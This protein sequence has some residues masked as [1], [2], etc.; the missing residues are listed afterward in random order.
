MG[1]YVSFP[2]GMMAAFLNRPLVL[3]EQNSIPGLANRVLAQLADRVLT[4]FPDAF[5][6]KAKV[7]WTGNPVRAAIAGLPEPAIRYGAR[8]GRLRLLV[9]GG[10][11]GA[12]ALNG[13]VPRALALIAEAQRPSVTH[14]SGVNHIAA[15]EAEYRRAGIDAACVPFI[16]DMARAYADSDVIICRAG[17]TTIAELA[18]AGVASVLVPYPHAVDD[19]QT[20]NARFLAERGAALLIDQRE[21]TPERLAQLLETCTRERLLDMAQRAREAAKPHAARD[22]ARICMELA[23]AA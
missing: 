9:V 4:S 6:K 16:D 3:H 15:V 23:H 21:L 13:A 1:G 20:R 17:A 11:L 2:G 5:G 8:S 19:H 22:V 10:S 7:T 12:Q 18:A 14:Q